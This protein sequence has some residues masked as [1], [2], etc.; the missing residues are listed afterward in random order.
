[1][2]RKDCPGNAR[3]WFTRRGWVGMV[4]PACTRC[5]APNPKWTPEREA[6]SR[7]ELGDEVVDEMLRWAAGEVE[8]LPSL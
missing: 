4:L 1:M 3:H 6:L 2:D 7:I 5:K 8:R